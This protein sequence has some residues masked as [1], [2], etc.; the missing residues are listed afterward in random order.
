MTF[1]SLMKIDQYKIS[2]INKDSYT[3]TKNDVINISNSTGR[4]ETDE[5]SHL[6][7]QS[8]G[9]VKNIFKKEGDHVTEGEIIATLINDSAIA[10]YN[11]A[12]HNLD[13]Y[14]WQKERIINGPKESSKNVS[15]VNTNS[16]KSNLANLKVE[17]DKILENLRKIL[18]SSD[19]EAR[20]E[21]INNEDTPPSIYGNYVCD[22]EGQYTVELYKSSSESGYSFRLSGLEEGV[23]KISSEKYSK[24]GDCGLFILLN[25][26]ESYGNEKWIIDIPNTRGSSYLTNLNAYTLAN[27]QKYKLISEAENNLLLAESKERDLNS[28]AS[29]EEINQVESFINQAKSEIELNKTKIEN[30]VIKAPFSGTI[31][32]IDFHIGQLINPDNKVSIIGNDVFEFIAFIPEIDIKN[33]KIGNE[34]HVVFDSSPNETF[35]G[36]VVNISRLSTQINNVSY[37]KTKIEI[38]NAPNWLR[39]GLNADIDIVTSIK[40]DVLSIPKHYIES[41]ENKSY[42][43]VIKD[44]KIEKTEIETGATGNDGLIE[45]FNVQEGTKIVTPQLLQQ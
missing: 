29:I 2:K 3:I 39:E 33:I 9:I 45:I 16:A 5:M 27:E 20:T 44:N 31:T 11:I 37:Y 23:F 19:I 32:D 12:F 41:I 26:D 1:V 22:K 24:L 36:Q 15:I 42:I 8:T 13:Y 14:K 21:N 4:I 18:L 7:F 25:P 34:A 17:Q 35:T 28:S 30:Y 38:K 6:S 10:E 40:K 43:F